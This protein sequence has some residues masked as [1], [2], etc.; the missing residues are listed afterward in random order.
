M[1]TGKHEHI[2]SDNLEQLTQDILNDKLFGFVRVDI[3]TPEDLKEKLSEMTPIFK[4]A[5]I[6]F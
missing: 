1:P 6:K 2:K 4:N 5:E 3:K